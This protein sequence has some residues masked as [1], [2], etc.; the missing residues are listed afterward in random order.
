MNN[1]I[2]IMVDLE[3]LS[4]QPNAAII[5][6]GAVRFDH[7]GIH[8]EFYVN[9]VDERGHEEL[10]TVKWWEEQG[11]EAKAILTDPKPF[12]IGVALVQFTCWLLEMAVPKEAEVRMWGNGAAFDNVILSSAYKRCDLNQPWKFYND[13]CFRTI[14]NLY[15]VEMHFSGIKH[16]A[17]D[18]AKH[19]AS[20]MVEYLKRKAW[21]D[22]LEGN[23]VWRKCET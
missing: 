3:T 2:N 16:Y 9:T 4:T 17:L 18:D 6:I 21:F 15:P 8:E 12:A 1:H 14:K 7:E 20:F 22:E 5:S 11:E 10:D 19:Q 23:Y 13:R